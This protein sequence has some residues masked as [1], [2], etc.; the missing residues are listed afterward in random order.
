[1][2]WLADKDDEFFAAVVRYYLATGGSPRTM[3]DDL[4]TAVMTV[5]RWSTGTA[6]PHP[7]MQKV[8]IRYVQ[9]WMIPRLVVL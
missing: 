3:A 8:V 5:E 2:T 1:M 6:R 9:E 7:R 4:E